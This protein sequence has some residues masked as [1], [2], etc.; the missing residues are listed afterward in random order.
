MQHEPRKRHGSL[1][2]RLTTYRAESTVDASI[3]FAPAERALFFAPTERATQQI[4]PQGGS[5]Y[6]LFL[7]SSQLH[8]GSLVAFDG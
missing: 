2:R 8:N 6:A 4:S 7:S 5:P 1:I 3:S